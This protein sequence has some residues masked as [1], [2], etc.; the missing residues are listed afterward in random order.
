MPGMPTQ[1]RAA[2]HPELPQIVGA[3][4]TRATL[5]AW[6][7]ERSSWACLGWLPCS[8]RA[9]SSEALAR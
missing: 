9:A 4:A 2:K 7:S 8:S 5:E 3:A 6:R 1:T